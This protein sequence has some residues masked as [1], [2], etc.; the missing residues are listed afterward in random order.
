MRVVK[1]GPGQNVFKMI[2]RKKDMLYIKLDSTNN[3]E[4]N[5]IEVSKQN[6]IEQLA[7]FNSTVDYHQIQG[8]GPWQCDAY[9]PN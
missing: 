7:V 3:R 6:L 9:L 8:C 5:K 2:P 1:T 4:G